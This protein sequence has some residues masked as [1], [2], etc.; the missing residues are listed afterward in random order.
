LTG[1]SLCIRIFSASQRYSLRCYSASYSSGILQR[2]GNPVRYKVCSHPALRLL[3]QYDEKH[4]SGLYDTLFQYLFQDRSIQKG[5]EALHIHRNSFLYRIHRIK[6]LTQIDL[7]D[8]SARFYLMLS[9]LLERS[10]LL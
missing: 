10:S 5:A 2:A 1:V 3:R 7:E 9:F 6:E 8:P 4:G